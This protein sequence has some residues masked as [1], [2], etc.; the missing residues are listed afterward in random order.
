MSQCF[1]QP[2][3]VFAFFFFFRKFHGM[4]R[5]IINLPPGESRSNSASSTRLGFVEFCC[6]FNRG[7][8]SKP[9]KN[10]MNS[11]VGP[12]GLGGRN[13]ESR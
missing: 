10:T 1:C 4:T 11:T 5:F 8:V 7:Q 2:F 3:V 6:T 9:P 13:P 12:L